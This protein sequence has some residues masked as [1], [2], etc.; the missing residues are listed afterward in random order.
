MAYH[1]CKIIFKSTIFFSC[2]YYLSLYINSPETY[3]DDWGGELT[4]QYFG[5]IQYLKVQLP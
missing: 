4:N 1:I 5:T 3:F 2:F